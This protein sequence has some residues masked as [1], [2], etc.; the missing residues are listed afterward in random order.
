MNGG[1]KMLREEFKRAAEDIAENLGNIGEVRYDCLDTPWIGLDYSARLDVDGKGFD[2]WLHTDTDEEDPTSGVMRA[3][4]SISFDEALTPFY[5]LEEIAYLKG[6]SNF[7]SRWAFWAVYNYRLKHHGMDLNSVFH[8]SMIRVYGD[9]RRDIDEIEVIMNHLLKN[10]KDELICYKFGHVPGEYRLRCFS[11]AFWVGLEHNPGYWAFFPDCVGLD[12]GAS[13]RYYRF[14]EKYIK[15]LEEKVGLDLRRY[16]VDYEDLKMFLLKNAT[17]FF[18]IYNEENYN[19]IRYWMRPYRVIG[20]SK[21]KFEEFVERYE[22]KKYPQALRD[23][24]ALVQDA[25][26]YVLMEKGVETPEKPDIRKFTHILIKNN[27]IDGRLEN[28]FAAFTSIANLATHGDFPNEEE[29]DDLIIVR[30]V[31]MTIKLGLH[32]LKELDSILYEKLQEFN[33]FDI[34]IE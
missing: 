31:H 14:I 26:E 32:L 12:S 19:L 33:S 18:S 15:E 16:D 3:S 28:W 11:Y 1:Y 7:L 8:E 13:R 17:H 24:R 25:Q 22:K 5:F 10:Q 27:I 34:V 20:D 23:L 29:I 30:R 21:N 4:L 2:F 6:H 9:P